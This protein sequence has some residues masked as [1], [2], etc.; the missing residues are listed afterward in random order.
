MASL[1]SFAQRHYQC[2]H[3]GGYSSAPS[4]VWLRYIRLPNFALRP[5]QAQKK[6]KMYSRRNLDIPTAKPYISNPLHESLRAAKKTGAPCV[7]AYYSLLEQKY[8]AAP[9]WCLVFGNKP[10]HRRLTGS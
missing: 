4:G 9:P 8:I 10:P 3:A 1:L 7:T 6:T 5:P 2:K